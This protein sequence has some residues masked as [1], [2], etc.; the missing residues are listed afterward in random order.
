MINFLFK[1]F[2]KNSCLRCDQGEALKVIEFFDFQVS[3]SIIKFVS[4][5]TINE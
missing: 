5:K 2:K 4:G 3:E 1:I